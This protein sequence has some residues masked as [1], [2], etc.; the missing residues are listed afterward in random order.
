MTDKRR[1]VD[2]AS[3]AELDKL[4][5]ITPEDIERAKAAWEKNAS[6]EFRDLLNAQTT[7]SREGR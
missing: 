2:A 6:P 3:E 1:Q 7:Q 4:A 5:E